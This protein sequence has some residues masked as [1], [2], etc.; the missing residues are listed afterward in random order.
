MVQ[1]ILW[2]GIAT[3]LFQIWNR[4]PHGEER[5]GIRD[6]HAGLMSSHNAPK[7]RQ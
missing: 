4:G 7:R 1:T 5:M 3:E 6:K 2:V